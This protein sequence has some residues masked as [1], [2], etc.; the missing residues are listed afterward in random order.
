MKREKA[1]AIAER[2]EPEMAY[3]READLILA[4]LERDAPADDEEWT[5]STGALRALLA[6][7]TT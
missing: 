7:R 4:E 5:I 3:N 1:A 6:R 2:I